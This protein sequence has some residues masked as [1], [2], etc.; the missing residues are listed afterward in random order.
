LVSVIAKNAVEADVYAKT[1]LI[2]GAARGSEFL[3]RVD[4]PGLFVMDDGLVSASSQWPADVHEQ[5]GG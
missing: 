3:A 4:C 2:L 5:G 1:A